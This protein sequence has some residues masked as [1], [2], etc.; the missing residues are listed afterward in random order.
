MKEG[1]VLRGQGVLLKLSLQVL[2][3]KGVDWGF[4]YSL[5]GVGWY[6]SCWSGTPAVKQANSG[7]ICGTQCETSVCVCV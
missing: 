1:W 7:Q 4:Y 3:L 2:F 6:P 5:V